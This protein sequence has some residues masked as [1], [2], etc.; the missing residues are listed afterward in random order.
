MV[1]RIGP[2]RQKKS[3]AEARTQATTSAASSQEKRSG[4]ASE[5]ETLSPEKRIDHA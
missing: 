4:S 5:A 3:V 2:S 1:R